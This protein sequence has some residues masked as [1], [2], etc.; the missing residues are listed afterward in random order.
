VMFPPNAIRK[1][2][3]DVPNVLLTCEF[4]LKILVRKN[5]AGDGNRT[6]ITSL[7]RCGFNPAPAPITSIV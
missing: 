3:R 1:H 5:G 4:D 7:G 2:L 6:R